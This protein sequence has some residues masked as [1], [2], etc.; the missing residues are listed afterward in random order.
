MNLST[1]NRSDLKPEIETID[2]IHSKKILIVSFTGSTPHLETSLEILRRLTPTN[3]IKY[4]HLGKYVSRPTLYPRNFIKRK[5]QFIYRIHR[6]KKYI[7]TYINSKNYKIWKDM[8]KLEQTVQSKFSKI[9]KCLKKLKIN[10]NNDLKKIKFKEYNIGYGLLNNLISDSKN[11]KPFPL[12]KKLNNE[13]KEQYYSSIK[14]IL[15]G[16][17]LLKNKGEFDT[18]IILNGRFNCEHSF[19]QVALNKNINIFYHECG[20]PYPKNRFF[21]E[22]YMPQNFDARKMEMRNLKSRIDIDKINQDGEYFFKEKVKGEGVYEKSYVKDQN[23]FLSKK[24]EQKINT[25]KESKKPVITFFT[26][27]DDEFFA[28]DGETNRYKMWESQISA[29]QKICNFN[30]NDE[31]LFIVRVHPNL[32]NKSKEEQAHWEKDG[33]KII[34]NNCLWV[35]QHSKESTYIILNK[36]DIVITAG[37]SVGVE[38][39]Y[40]EKISYTIA[41]CYYDDVIDP[42][43]WISNPNDLF[44]IIKN[45]RNIIKPNRI[46]CYLYGAWTMNYGSKFKYFQQNEY[47]YGEMENNFKVASPG[48]VQ[49]LASNIKLFIKYIL[50]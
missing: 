6:A 34:S 28:I 44:D 4:V 13:L 41:K 35:D 8:T 37:S 12:N 49:R 17:E 9:D 27:N 10:N 45:Y 47:G 7:K 36:S 26:S 20:A 19:K 11:T 48:R 5:T 50:S 43:K 39:V 1:N 42:I 30:K 18:L 15:F 22:N 29:I 16:E 32:K 31:F 3:T 40:L 24:I 14:S 21:F 23:K 25:Y 2:Q 38:A 33:K 46:D